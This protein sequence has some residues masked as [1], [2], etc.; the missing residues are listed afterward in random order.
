MKEFFNKKRVEL[1][2]AEISEA[3]G[4]FNVD[5]FIMQACAGLNALEL[6]ERSKH[7]ANA[8]KMQLPVETKKNYSHAISQLLLA[9]GD[10]V[11]DGGLDG[12]DGFHHL[13]Y[14]DFVELYGHPYPIQSLKALERMTQFFSAEFAIRPFLLNDSEKTVRQ[15]KRWSKH[16]DWRVR[17][18]A[19]EGT[20]PRLPWGK[21]IP[22]FIK[23]PS[24]ILP[25]LNTL[26]DDTNLVVR[27]SVANN[28][29]DISK[30]H[31]EL[32]ANLATD[33]L[34]NKS[35][36]AQWTAKHGLRTL[37]KQGNS[38]ALQAL[39]FSGGENI[40]ASNFTVTPKSLSIGE[41]LSISFDLYSEEKCSSKLVIDYVLERILAN[42]KLARKVFKI[43][44]TTM[45]NGQSLKFTKH[46]DF[47]QR[48]TRTYYPGT[49]TIHIQVNGFIIAHRSFRLTR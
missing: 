34:S 26:Y 4:N 49:H 38:T 45:G 20:R 25:I 36:S 12:M 2:A 42:G 8:M 18:L 3:V 10:P 11:D 22:Q 24:D 43:A 17:R 27:R 19:S 46:H 47:T 23:D 37:V 5:V 9:M 32:A 7:I 15:M 44:N 30:D 16:R 40:T 48:S 21:Q 28:L 35:E 29:N 39:G 6:K 1:I 41:K 31:P 13:P 33:W 14:L